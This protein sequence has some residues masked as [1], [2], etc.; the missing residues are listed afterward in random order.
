MAC[1]LSSKMREREYPFFFYRTPFPLKSENCPTPPSS[2]SSLCTPSPPPLK[3]SDFSVNTYKKLKVTKFLVQLS[4]FRFLVNTDKNIFF[5]KLFLSLN[6]SDF[7][8]FIFY[9]K[10]GSPA[11]RGDG[12]EEY[13]F[14]SIRITC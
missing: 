9:A 11:E 13:Y 2:T 8:L 4:Q 7:S 5:Y 1:T 14:R 10:T 12:S 3:K 6:I